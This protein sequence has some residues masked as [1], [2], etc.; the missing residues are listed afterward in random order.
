MTISGSLRHPRLVH[1]PVD[2]PAGTGLLYIP[3]FAY[4]LYNN[5]THPT[6]ELLVLRLEREGGSRTKTLYISA[7]VKGATA[8]ANSNVTVSTCPDRIFIR[9]NPSHLLRSAVMLETSRRKTLDWMNSRYIY[10]KIVCSETHV[11][12]TPADLNS[13]HY[14]TQSFS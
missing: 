3:T 1:D 10:G 5:L 8:G 4:A 12:Q 7:L 2:D 11:I 6:F 14:Y 13:S 9:R